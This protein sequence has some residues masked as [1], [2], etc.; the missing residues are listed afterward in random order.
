MKDADEKIF[1]AYRSSVLNEKKDLSE[2]SEVT[3]DEVDPY[4]KAFVEKLFKGTTYDITKQ[5]VWDGIHGVIVDLYNQFNQRGIR[6]K[7][8][9]LKKIMADKK[10]RW[11]DIS[12]IG[13]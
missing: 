4:V 13:L 7:K 3:F 9:D 2:A 12:A 11:I 10:V 6:V 5:H 8:Q 1:E